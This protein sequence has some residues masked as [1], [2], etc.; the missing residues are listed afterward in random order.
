MKYAESK[1]FVFFLL[2]NQVSNSKEKKFQ[3]FNWQTSKYPVN[4]LD[5]TQSEVFSLFLERNYK[6]LVAI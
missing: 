3:T 1:R 6:I 4:Y 5:M 2:S